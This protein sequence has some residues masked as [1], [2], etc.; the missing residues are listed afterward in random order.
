MAEAQRASANAVAT[1]KLREN[2]GG[3]KMTVLQIVA[4]VELALLCSGCAK[5][6]EVD[7]CVEAWEATVKAIPDDV[8]VPLVDR[9]GTQKWTTKSTMR[10]DQRLLCLKAA[11]KV[12]E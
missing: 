4:I 5:T 2:I 11:G 7:K 10:Y 3:Q 12:H 1:K 6:S 8:A 9:N